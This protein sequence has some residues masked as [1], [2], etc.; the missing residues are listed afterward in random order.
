MD[1][2]RWIVAASL[3]LALHA[4]AG[5]QPPQLSY[6]EGH[7]G[8][9]RDVAITSDGRLIV[10]AGIDGTLRIW[11]R[12]TGQPLRT[13]EAH[14]KPLLNLA[15][16]PSGDAIA[17][18]SVDGRIKLFD[19]PRPFPIRELAG[20][21]A[22]PDYLAVTSDDTRLLTADASEVLRLFDLTTKQQVREFPGAT[23]GVLGIAIA[24]EPKQ[25]LATSRDG[26]LRSW[27]LEN[28]QPGPT[29]ALAAPSP[30]A[31]APGGKL[32]V[33][34][35]E[36]GALRLAVWP[37]L[38]A[39]VLTT[40]ADQA[41]S[42]AMSEGGQAVL[43]GSFDQQVILNFGG[44]APRPLPGA[45]GRVFSVALNADASLAAA[46]TEQGLVK[47]WKTADGAD[48]GI[49]A[50]HVGAVTSIAFHPQQPLVATAG[51]D[52][53]LRIWR[54]SPPLPPL[55]GHTQPV[56]TLAISG[57]GK[58]ALA[59]GADKS[60]RIW[61]VTDGTQVAAWENLP[62]PVTAATFMPDASAVVLGDAT[63]VLSLRKVAD[64]SV[65]WSLLAHAGP[66]ADVALLA[67]GKLASAAAS[68]EVKIWRL[69]AIGQPRRLELPAAT[70]VLPLADGKSVLL[71]TA[72]GEVVR[73]EPG[74]KEKAEPAARLAGAITALAASGDET[75]LFAGSAAGEVAVIDPAGSAAA[76]TMAAH[77]GR[78]RSIAAHPQQPQFAT[79]GDDGLVRL[80]NL[81]QPPKEL[82]G[83]Q[84]PVTAVAVSPDG[85]Q[86]A[87]GDSSGATHRWSL[88]DGVDAGVL[89]GGSAAVRTLAYRRDGVELASGDGVGIIRLFQAADAAALG[90]IGAHDDAVTGLSYHPAG[91]QLLSSGADGMLRLWQLPLVPPQ[92][93]HK[94]AGT[95]SALVVTADG[96]TALIAGGKTAAIVDLATAKE[97]A[98]IAAQGDQITAAAV[99]PDNLHAALVTDR[100]TL[101]VAALA[102]GQ[103][104]AEMGACAEGVNAV[105]FRP[106]GGQIATAG[107]DGEVRLWEMPKTPRSFSDHTGKITA[108]SVSPSGQWLATASSD[109]TVRLW[110]LADGTASWTLGHAEPVAAIAWKPDSAQIATA[111]GNIVQVWNVADGQSAMQLDKLGEQIG[112][113][114]FAADGA[115]IFAA[116][117][118]RVVRQWN[119]ADGKLLRSLGEH[120]DQLVSLQLAAGGSVLASS[121]RDGVI[122]TWNVASGA[123]LQNIVHQGQTAAASVSSDGK[124]LAVAGPEKSVTLYDLAD[125]AV[126]QTIELASA[127]QCVAFSGDQLALATGESDGTVRIW[128]LQGELLEFV[129][130]TGNAS[131]ALAFLPDHRQ[132]AVGSDK[133]LVRVHTR[134]LVKSL[135]LAEMPLTAL[136]W[137]ADGQFIV[138]ASSDK[139]LR[140][141]SV[142]DGSQPR[143][144]YGQADAATCVAITKD[145]TKVLAGC[146]DRSLRVWNYS[147]GT[148][149]ATILLED[150]P[151]SL[152]ATADGGRI[153][154]ADGKQVRV[155]DLATQRLSERLELAATSLALLADGKSLLV[156]DGAGITRRITLANLAVTI[157][158]AGHASGAA[159]SNDGQ[160]WFSAGK[161]K[162][163]KVWDAL[164]KPAAP[165]GVTES[166]AAAMAIR[167]DGLQLAVAGQDRQIHLWRLD[168]NQL[169]R[170]IGAGSAVVSLAYH[171]SQPKLAAACADGRIRIYNPAD[172]TLLETI[173]SE[174]PAAGVAFAGDLVLAGHADHAVRLHSAALQRVLPGHQGAVTSLVYS[175]DGASVFSGGTDMTV[176]QWNS[177]DGAA[178]RAV[179]T[180]AGPITGVALSSDGLRLFAASADKTIRAHNVADGA[181]MATYTGAAPVRSLAAH[182]GGSLLAA[183]GEDGS[184]S[185]WDSRTG[186][187]REMIGGIATPGEALAF[188]ADGKAIFASG[189]D[190]QLL[191]IPLACTA[192]FPADPAA[193]HDL[194]SA[195]AGKELVSAGSD[196]A[197][198]VWDAN[199][200]LL[201]TLAGAGF[202][203]RSIAVR[204]DGQQIIAGGDPSQ[205]QPILLAWNAADGQLQF[206]VN[207]GAA[208]NRVAYLDDERIAVACVDQRIR[209]LR[210]ADGQKLEEIATPATVSSAAAAADATILVGAADSKLYRLRP[211][212]VRSIAAH[213]GGASVV[214]WS[215][216][217][218]ELFSGG[219]D[220]LIRRWQADSG[221]PLG[222]FGGSPAAITSISLSADGQRLIASCLDPQVRMWDL[223][224]TSADPAAEVAPTQSITLPAAV[225]SLALTT[226]NRRLIAG[227]EDGLVR[228]WDLASGKEMERLSGHT[229]AVL[230]VAAS[231]DGS[232][233][234]SAGAD[235]TV[236]KNGMTIQRLIVPEEGMPTAI[237][238]SHGGE[239][240]YLGGAG[241]QVRCVSA[242]D[243]ASVR[244]FVGG[245]LPVRAIA[246]GSQHKLIA[247]GGDD[248]HLRIWSAEDA[249]PQADIDVHTPL[250]AVHFAAEDRRIVVGGADGILRH[251]EL[252]V[253]DGKLTTD[254]ILQGR[255]HV[256]A[257]R[258]MV[259]G[260]NRRSAFTV[261]ADGKVLSWQIA[262][263]QPRWTF[264]A[265]QGP[266]HA[267]AFNPPGTSIT[268]AGQD[269]AVRLL[270][271]ADGAVQNEWPGH[272]GG[273][274]G[275]A[276]RPDGQELATV[277]R[278]G[279][280][281]IWGADG[282]P[283]G[284][285]AADAAFP[286]ACVAWSS[287][288]ALLQIG[289]ASK[290]WHTFQR[291]ALAPAR[292]SIGHNHPLVALRHS[293]SGQRLAT[294]DESGKLFVWD[295]AAG[296]PLFHQQLDVTS[297]YR[298]SWS[299]DASEIAVA[300]SDPR[301][302]R[303]QVPAAAR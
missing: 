260:D 193:L 128:N 119:L 153:A 16:S 288:G 62:Q 130:P 5:A 33:L 122:R 270:A 293:A 87:T 239:Q 97:R 160:R 215:A 53:M 4:S 55:E 32:L 30:L 245:N 264:S 225:R 136:T 35:G 161:D 15:V 204:A 280:L 132:I 103:V 277:G 273:I 271:T 301:I 133:G 256:G 229:G 76:V 210:A 303:V 246:V 197:V 173:R 275:L 265:G 108:A 54:Q 155:F 112:A 274:S 135:P 7:Q 159:I 220:K 263:S 116:G 21:P 67:D 205:A 68:G 249:S 187:L 86:A 198:K 268:A 296:T 156:A 77:A 253:K 48:D 83:H 212:L 200:N 183:A 182:R 24:G 228:L 221:Q 144:L 56:T 170:K 211:A 124:W 178:V 117:K 230:A 1:A 79:A 190:G 19:L 254:L 295:A 175:Q 72:S 142:T 110:N 148:L 59:S 58:T 127:P 152:A 289:G 192:Q 126:V 69:A 100:G 165:L 61:S 217:G 2:S 186:T 203:L 241:G 234:A 104:I 176:R 209:I 145:G 208:I 102:D 180:A 247:A 113:I 10:S 51:A 6:L 281:L 194:S 84:S 125:G 11:D 227:C 250:T 111:S 118:D 195:A 105:A 164:G 99:S 74:S 45:G 138:S 299:P 177:A 9:V 189:T 18:G 71:G 36:D 65:T 244:Q 98:T 206:N 28:G 81:P 222:V 243:L 258:R 188:A 285:A 282:K 232:L 219:A 179:T 169:E 94:G 17:A 66:I 27:N 235:R 23:G 184:I 162:S 199:G 131:T 42:L 101:L 134:A 12:A 226:D 146:R 163:V 242:A 237:A 262:D 31:V 88:P 123:P 106:Q 167:G 292:E 213:E 168:N 267:V 300:T 52:G 298:L 261:A 129:P 78:V 266:I 26:Q 185:L 85:K 20:F 120:A 57:D 240:I 216:S 284:T 191:S 279:R 89:A 172:G 231:R 80:W 166:A 90:S 302:I 272:D 238:F 290:L 22:V 151:V 92:E 158:H 115:S 257:I 14:D 269:G 196:G 93:V 236:R 224:T 40:H 95:I 140:L 38:S 278:D 121:G 143:Q 252:A 47:L 44:S 49:L 201:R 39:Q 154:I 259:L 276:W 297:A 233:A 8:A 171:P 251:Y 207:V 291:A 34:P 70:A 139:T 149:L 150:A 41:T 114:A 283:A 248:M 43:S 147:D 181:A 3:L 29:I 63:G 202:A 91:T 82:A 223:S 13:L 60:V 141:V 255:G 214:A 107:R 286:F 37:P 96:N 218:K 287:D 157:A 109:K 73:T 174:S 137:S 46:G 50:G 25:A 64:G 75:R 294:L